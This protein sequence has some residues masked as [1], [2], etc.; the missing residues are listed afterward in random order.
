[1]PFLVPAIPAITAISS[2][3]AAGGGLYSAIKGA[4]DAPSPD[5]LAS[6]QAP[7][8]PPA[9]GTQLGSLQAAPMPQNQPN[10]YNTLGQ[11]QG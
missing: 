5:M 10:L 6:N 11:L 8:L 4:P 1:M 7:S 9:P 3:A 2:A